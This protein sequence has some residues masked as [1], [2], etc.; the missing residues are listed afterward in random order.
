VPRAPSLGAHPPSASST[1]SRRAA[2][3]NTQHADVRH[4]VQPGRD[5][6]VTNAR[7]ATRGEEHAA[8]ACSTQHHTT[9]AAATWHAA[10]RRATMCDATH[11]AMA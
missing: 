3:S 6:G 10:L 8:Y 11:C 2:S 4:G 7:R 9:N 5:G 1:T